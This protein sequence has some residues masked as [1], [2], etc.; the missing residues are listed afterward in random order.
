MQ[1][2]VNKADQLT[3]FLAGLTNSF[4]V[5]C[6]TETWYRHET[7]V[8]RM[9]GYNSFYVNRTA[10]RGGG[11]ALLVKNTYVCELL[12]EHCFCNEDI[13]ML[14]V[15][16]ACQT[17]SV[18]YRRPQGN[19]S[20]FFY[21]FERE[22]FLFNSEKFS[23]CIAGDF[24]IDMS[25][26]S[27][28][29]QQLSSIIQAAGFHSVISSPTRITATCS[30]LLD[31][32]ITN[33]NSAFLS[34]RIAVD[35]SDHLPIFLF[36]QK[37]ID[38][39]AN[40]KTQRQLLSQERLEQFRSHIALVDWAPVYKENTAD[41]AYSKFLEMFL[42][43]YN[44]CFPIVTINAP[45]NARKPWM[46]SQLTRQVK[47]KHKMFAVFI[48]TRDTDVLAQYK[49]LRNRLNREIRVAR[50]AYYNN[51]FDKN[52]SKKPKEKWRCLNML[53]NR[54]TIGRNITSLVIEGNVT[55]GSHLAN[56]FNKFFSEVG[57]SDFNAGISSFLGD[58]LGPSLFFAPTDETE[59]FSICRKLKDTSSLDTH[60][61][62]SRP[63]KYV[64][65]I[66]TPCLT[67]I[68]NTALTTAHFPADMQLA[69]VT[70]IYKKGD[71]N[72]LG[73][74]RPV[75][76]L[77][78]FSK[79]LEQLIRVRLNGFL[80]KHSV[81]TDCQYG[82]TQNRSTEHAL[83]VQKEYILKNFE[84]QLLT[85]GIFVDFSKAFDCLNHDILFAKLEHYGVRGHA[86]N[87]LKSY[88]GSRSQYVV[89]NNCAS[90]TLSISNGVPQGS[91]LGP[92][93]FNVYIN[94]IPNISTHAKYIIYAD[95]TSLFFSSNDI[96]HLEKI[97]NDALSSLAMWSSVNSLKINK[98]KTKAVLFLPKRKQVFLPPCLYLGDTVI[99]CVDT[100]KSLGITFSN[101]MSWDAHVNNLSTTL[102][103]IIGITS[104]NRYIF[105]TK[106]KLTLYYA[107]FYS[108]ISYCL[109]VWGNTTVSN[110]IKLQ[111]LQKKMLRAIVN[112]SYDSPTK[113]IF[114]Q[115]NIVPVNKLFDYRFA[116]FYKRIIRKNDPFLSKIA[117][118]TF[119]HSSYDTRAQSSYVLPKCRTNYGFSMLS[120]IV[121]NFLNTSSYDC[122][123]TMSLSAILKSII[124][125]YVSL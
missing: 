36:L 45:K 55:S 100:F 80:L 13:E 38:S 6:L 47:K 112:G 24:N 64:L 98:Q 30:S 72:V 84:T 115:Y 23:S 121:P 56:T 60:N 34:G 114:L 69:R 70:V 110:I 65:D 2:A 49:S 106:T 96:G 10:K 54:N 4:D 118:L 78:Y 111:A 97:A 117:P 105:P 22:I 95:D 73:N 124:Q 91:I 19:L 11:V 41:G 75:S 119:R 74:Y 99:E 37:Q 17:F 50:T 42:L 116:C 83:L 12:S 39:K 104:R 76:I 28:A 85:L 25:T 87:L 21:Y 82:F 52:L 44:A 120:Y 33:S 103:R 5:I 93:L 18:L 90:Q 57:H 61:I 43:L 35:I 123:N 68:Y 48:K 59:V 26:P 125:Q 77:P 122:L 9:P 101:T 81:I 88:L 7:D 8:L 31:L 79:G 66:I 102:S 40:T 1:S 113:H 15:K 109:L 92:L 67:H 86:L 107:F 20:T 94:D 16:S 14:T 89:I 63:V 3:H 29:Q 71:A 32:I 53:L 58:K 46:T 27:P 51:L 108:H 62:Q